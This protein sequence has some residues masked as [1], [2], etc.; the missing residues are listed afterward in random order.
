MR[1]GE[2]YSRRVFATMIRKACST[3]PRSTNRTAQRGKHG[4]AAASAEVHVTGRNAFELK[5][6]FARFDALPIAPD[7]PRQPR[8]PEITLLPGARR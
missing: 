6:N 1:R 4:Q 7:E 5:S 3:I 8:L 2:I